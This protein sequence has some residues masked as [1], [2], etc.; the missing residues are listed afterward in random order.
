MQC[1]IE[2]KP[3]LQ[4][5]WVHQLKLWFKEG[6]WIWICCQGLSSATQFA[7]DEF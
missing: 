7:V 6:I 3:D 4:L 2:E 5:E 1:V